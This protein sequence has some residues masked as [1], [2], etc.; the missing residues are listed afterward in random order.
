MCKGEE[1]MPTKRN[2]AGEQQNYVPQGNG[3]ASGEYADNSSGSN[4]HFT[5][6]KKPDEENTKNGFTTFTK[7]EE[8]PQE[9]ETDNSQDIKSTRRKTRNSLIGK[10]VNPTRENDITLG[11]VID[12]SNDES[13][14]V[15]GEYLNSNDKL[16][17]QFGN[18]GRNAAGYATGY[19][20]IVTNHSTHTIRHELGHTFDNWYGKDLPEN[21]RGNFE[22]RDYASVKFVDDETNKTMNEMLHEELGVNMYKATMSGW[23]MS[24][25]KLGVDKRETKIA[26]AN[27]ITNVFNKYADKIFD[28]ITGIPNS[29]ERY[30][31]LRIQYNE[32]NEN[33]RKYMLET[34]EGMELEQAD[35]KVREA[36]NNYRNEMM[37]KGA[38]SI[39]YDDSPEVRGA[40]EKRRAIYERYQKKRTELF[41]E[42][43]GEKN[44]QEHDLLSRKQYEV[45]KEIEGIAG[46][47]G[48]TLDY[49]GAGS[50]FYSTNGHGSHYFNQRKEAGYCLE[51]F[52]NMFDCYMSKDSWKKE[53]VKEMFPKTS[54]IFEKIYYKK[55]KK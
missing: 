17:I 27:N 15:L 34:Q 23:R 53:C 8:K 7:G 45:Y 49:L 55:G 42:K 11:E 29:R 4:I 2:R 13:I 5:N 14:G 36:E 9:I 47:V 18:A 51:I 32:L 46:I 35:A 43:F 20:S 39:Y 22:D 52:A 30:K 33:M 16:K 1:T 44:L 26:A 6:F 21:G 31:E 37:R 24:Y 12:N 54:K 25:R 48:D 19:S 41:N 10:C 28:K 40:R 3:D 38:W 50:S